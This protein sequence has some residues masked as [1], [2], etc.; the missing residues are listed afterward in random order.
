[1]SVSNQQI[2]YEYIADGSTVV[3]PFSCRVVYPSDITV[4]IDGKQAT[5]YRVEGVDHPNGGNVVFSVAPVANSR[6]VLSRDIPLIRET[7][8][9]TNGDFLAK[10]VNRDFDR[11]WMALQNAFSWVRRALRYPKNGTNYDAENR[12]IENLGYPI[13]QKDAT[14]KYY[15]DQEYDK[16]KKAIDTVSDNMVQGLITL[17]SFEKGATLRLN[18][19]VLLW[20]KDG[21]Y[22]RWT[23]ALPKTVDVNSTPHNSGGI[24]G[25]K[26]VFIGDSA[27]RNELINNGAKIVGYNNGTVDS[28]LAENENS[29]SSLKNN[30]IQNG[31]KGNV[32]LKIGANIANNNN[33]LIVVYGD[34]TTDGTGTSGWTQNPIDSANNA[35]GGIDHNLQAPNSWPVKLNSILQDMFSDCINV[36]NAGY[37]GRDIYS[38]WAFRNYKTAVLNTYGKPD[39]V[40]VAFGLNDVAY[41][42]FSVKRFA[43]EYEKL[44]NLIIEN[45]SIP[46]LATPDPVSD[47]HRTPLKVQG[48][49]CNII[50]DIAKRKGLTVLDLNS[51]LLNWQF[52]RRN[53]A[54]WGYH[55][56][57]RLHFSDL[58]HAL[59]AAYC[60]KKISGIVYPMEAGNKI[61][62]WTFS[63]SLSSDFIYTINNFFSG[64][65]QF[66]SYSPRQ[67]IMTGYIWVD[68]EALLTYYSVNRD[69]GAM[70]SSNNY[71]LIK[72]TQLPTNGTIERPVYFGDAGQDDNIMLSEMPLAVG[73]LSAGLNKIEYFAPSINSELQIGYFSVR[74]LQQ[75]FRTINPSSL[76]Y[77][78]SNNLRV[79]YELFTDIDEF[80]FY[81]FN[82]LKMH[83]SIPK[84]SGFLFLI[85]RVCSKYSDLT[86]KDAHAGLMIFRND[87]NSLSLMEVLFDMT[88]YISSRELAKTSQTNVYT[89]GCVINYHI[90]INKNNTSEINITADGVTVISYT[91]DSSKRPLPIC[92]TIGGF[93]YDKSKVTNDMISA[94]FIN[95]YYS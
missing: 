64:C 35:I 80:H 12:R 52:K 3:F 69:I 92:G 81:N 10:T 40:I 63:Q 27:L 32:L 16:V 49:A 5:S 44:L 22:Y 24:G 70:S 41:P 75:K 26:W 31:E 66:K 87:D 13:N 7:D 4:T 30:L 94:S 45:G 6:V 20:E 86:L 8:Y 54:R 60:A 51:F 72:L 50:K 1:M 90:F 58:G 56:P 93:Y 84:S 57:D 19:Q 82:N 11:L 28:A 14:T 78:D 18:N 25:G 62:S 34:S 46:I 67:K 61:P 59:K 55:Q 9:Q 37:G 74:T 53:N 36:K 48:T 79:G 88:G 23:G 17:E 2:Y 47:N 95:V 29:I 91:Q 71:P 33:C 42:G 43:D 89:D 83:L 65:L 39:Y 73:A 21:Q 77:F 76:N 68:Q 38:G 85:S 15:V